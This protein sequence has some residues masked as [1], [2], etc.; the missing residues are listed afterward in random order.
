MTFAGA[1]REG[2]SF[3]AQQERGED[4]LRALEEPGERGSAHGIGR[5][6]VG[7]GLVW[8]SSRRFGP[9]LHR[10]SGH[11]PRLGERMAALRWRNERCRGRHET[12]NHQ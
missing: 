3:F 7:V 6:P 2:R 1:L 8:F 12:M 10:A 9:S 5:A 4:A 11:P